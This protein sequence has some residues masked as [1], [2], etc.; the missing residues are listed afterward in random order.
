M[1]EQRKTYFRE[2]D[3][4]D[5]KELKV[6][7]AYTQRGLVQRIENLNPR[8]DALEIRAPI[9]P[10]KFRKGNLG[11]EASRKCFKHGALVAISQPDSLAEAYASHEIPLSLR[12][13]SLSELQQMKQEEI[14]F[15]GYSWKPVFG[16]NRTKRVVPF[17]WLPEGARI[18]SYAENYSAYKQRNP[19]TEKIEE[20]TGIKVEAYPDAK[21]VRTEGASVVVEVPSRTEKKSR[22]RF[23]FLHVPFIPNNPEKE[24]NYN[25]ATVLSLQPA[26]IREDEEAEPI[27]ART[28]HAIYD[29]QYKFEQSREQ[30]PVIRFT[31]QDIAGYLG[32]IKKQLTEQQNITA[33]MFNPFA[34]P[35]RHQAEFYKKLC[36][37]V[38]IYDPTLSNKDKLRK[39]HLAE[40][41]ILLA[42]A[43]GQF[44]HDDFA[45]WDPTR[46][47]VYKNFN[48]K[49]S[50]G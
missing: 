27:Q 47:G 43:I 26:L 23:G 34:L 45:Y 31:P 22:Y 40:K 15:V 5:I 4:R 3:T 44:G 6:S 32:I 21:K 36:N 37:N 7:Q 33:L 48:W 8:E 46:D 25:L 1:H 14:N 49:V 13:P 50:S 20:K 42:R 17:I 35:S 12:T 29:I 18:F 10:G 41:S 28:T 16:R 24:T 19:N 9:I 2:R 38:I 39:L 30:S 11:Y